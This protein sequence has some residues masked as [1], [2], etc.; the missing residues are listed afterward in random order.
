ML[1]GT[2]KLLPHVSRQTEDQENGESNDIEVAIHRS[3]EP[4]LKK[5]KSEEGYTI[6]GLEQTTKSECMYNFKWPHKVAIVVGHGK[7]LYLL[8]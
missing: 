1:C 2:S 5:L 7:F 6:V 3:L 8:P 4:V